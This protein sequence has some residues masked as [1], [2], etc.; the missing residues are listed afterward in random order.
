MA[1]FAIAPAVPGALIVGALLAMNEHEITE[2]VVLASIYF[3]YPIALAIGAPIH[4]LLLRSG[5]TQWLAYAAAGAALGALL[6]AVV[7]MAIDALVALQG[8]GGGRTSFTLS[9][10]PLAVACGA[11]AASAFWLIVRPDLHVRAPA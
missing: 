6:Y 10:L 1:G 8:V 7:P 11:V 5:F 3:A 9:V 4:A 2:V